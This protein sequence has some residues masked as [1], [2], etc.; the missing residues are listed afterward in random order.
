MES[1]HLDVFRERE[2]LGSGPS[3]AVFRAVK[4]DGS[5]KAV[6]LLDGMAINRA[7]LE[8]ACAR[9]ERDGWPKGVLRVDE[10][11]FRARPA[12]RLTACLAD[13]VEDG[14][15]RPRSL[16]YQL[17]EFPGDR[18]WPTVVG[19]AEGLAALHDR[20]VAH[21]N[22]KP[23]NVFF[24]DE[25]QVV[26]VD[27][28]LGHMPGI[29]HLEFTDACL[30]HPPE[31]LR[32]SDGYLE[33]EGYRWDVFAFGVMAYRL[34]TGVFP[35][36]D[37]TFQQVAPISG[38]TTREGIAADLNKIANSLDA[39]PG[40]NWPSEPVNLL[41]EAYR[42]V[43][44]ACL[45]L[46]PLARPANGMEV[47]RL[48]RKA[49][50]AVEEEIK[51]EEVL[52]QRRRSQR[53]AWRANVAAGVLAAAVVMLVMLWQLTRSQLK[54]S[55]AERMMDVDELGTK[56]QVVE[57]E[58]DEAKEAEKL[59]EQTLK[60]ESTTW[61]ARIEESREIGDHLFAWAMEKGSRNLPPLDGRELR[62]ARLDK[63]YERFL[64]RTAEIE[65]LEDERARAKLQ[66]AEISLASGDP[67]KSAA[68][69]EEAI[70]VAG[71][72]TEAG[73][74]L[75]LRLATD[76]LF[77]ALLR[78]QNND[79]ETDASF[80][81][82]REAL[83]AVP[84]SEVDADRVSQL[85]AILDIHESRQHAAAGDEAKALELLHRATQELNRLVANRPEVA[86]LR[87]EMVSCYLSSATILDG[88]GEMGDARTVRT[89]ASDVLVDLI[90]ENPGNLGF[91]IELAG[92]YGAIAESALI[93]GDLK[94]AESMSDAAVKLLVEVLPQRPDS[95]EARSQLAA[96]RGLMAGILRDRGKS[97]EAIELYDEGLHLI[98]GLTVGEKADPVARYRF[99]LL[100]WEKGRMLGFSGER[101]KEIE[102]QQKSVAILEDL[103]DS[104]YG[105][106][107]SEQLRRSLGYL[108][109][110]LGHAAHLE[111]ELKESANAF[112]KAVKVW[113]KLSRDRPGNE[114]YEEALEWNEQ[115]LRD[116]K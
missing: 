49:E 34:L 39:E 60:T 61:L 12:A 7:V 93:A 105:I 30:Y 29:G 76:R 79:P 107:R 111:K 96:Q 104:P 80:G 69:L 65:G 86:I 18:S 68:R 109:G 84:Q 2:L 58:R 47:R 27:W 24:D 51:R 64:E 44:D 101:G 108:L 116:L 3:G 19:L 9:L 83:E 33:E 32:S 17:E 23:G 53:A 20:Q 112:S 74:E 57:A 90:K 72:L 40:V 35:R 36:C 66:L 87:S 6:K 103:L 110:D 25:G 81:V 11:D 43:I 55:I 52:D 22:L 70:S 21:G 114:E 28:A 14:T 1:P 100:N 91:R 92:C 89:L 42:E 77:L 5:V 75:D 15:W 115:R 88:M 48:L 62:L 71:N 10:A 13:Q 82:A 45:A 16:Q 95:A 26:L 106:S 50:V 99:A 31:Q 8:K 102:H 56:V 98:E 85:L 78:Q 46:D 38:E 94:N 54:T 37:S 97:E 113:E 4:S 63:Y 73:A 67:V 41:E 59:A